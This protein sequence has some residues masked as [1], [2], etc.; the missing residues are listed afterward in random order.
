[1]TGHRPIHKRSATEDAFGFAQA[2]ISGDELFVAGILSVDQ[3]FNVLDP[4]DMRVQVRRVYS[5]L[6]ALLEEAG[7]AVGDIIQET[8]HV[9][10][11]AALVAAN[12]VRKEALFPASPATTAVQVSALV[13][14]GLVI[15]VSCLARRS[16]RSD[17]NP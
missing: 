2:V 10:D 17:S 9:T 7:F 5:E 3:A 16:G 8:V 6:G 15:E 14:P 1:M 11:M 13:L 12:E 4:D